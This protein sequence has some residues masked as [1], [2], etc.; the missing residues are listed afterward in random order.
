M[1]CYRLLSA[2]K[3]HFDFL[4]TAMLWET[5][6]H[7]F[8]LLRSTLRRCLLFVR[9]IVMKYKKGSLQVKGKK[10][11]L[12]LFF[13]IVSKHIYCQTNSQTITNTQSLST[14]GENR[15]HASDIWSLAHYRT[16]PT[17]HPM[18]DCLR[19]IYSSILHPNDTN[20]FCKWFLKL[21]HQWCFLL[22][23]ENVTLLQDA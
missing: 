6:P 5:L 11:I 15:T 13:Y 19:C 16:M 10:I 20:P 22:C 2:E 8:F 14:E 12:T 3:H 7:F 23:K 21:I 1:A 17:G 9:C 4:D 18:F